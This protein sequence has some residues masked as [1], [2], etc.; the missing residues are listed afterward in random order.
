L[1][2]RFGGEEFIVIL[3]DIASEEDA[4]NVAMKLKNKIAE[5]EIDVYAGSTIRK[6]TSVGFS[7][8]PKDSFS[9]T[10]VMKYADMALY[11][12]KENGRNQVKRYSKNEKEDEVELF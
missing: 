10:T 6:T 12:A 7:M 5:N 3:V 4:Y 2:I 8:F 9:L 11:E 1:V